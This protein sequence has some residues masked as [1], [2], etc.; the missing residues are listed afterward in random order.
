MARIARAC[1]EPR[2]TTAYGGRMPG[3]RT[4]FTVILLP[5]VV[6]GCAKRET[7]PFDG[8]R[9][10][11]HVKFLHEYGPRPAGSRALTQAADYIQ[12]K[13]KDLG[14]APQTQR[15]RE[16]E[17]KLELQN[18]WVQI[19]GEDPKD[20]PILVIGAHYDTKLCQGHP[21][22]AHNFRFVGAIDGTGGP[23]VLLELAGHVKQL[24][25]KPN[26]WLVWFDGEENLEFEWTDDN[27]ALFGSRHFVK[28][29]AAD[30]TRFPKD[31]QQRIKAMVLLDLV[32]DKNPK[33]DKDTYSNS[34]LLALFADAGD[35]MGEGARMFRTTSAIKD[36][37]LAF[38]NYGIPSI[39]LIDF[40]YRIPQ[41]RARPGETAPSDPRYFA[42]WHTD[43]DTPD[44][45]SPFGLKFFGDIVLLAL[46]AI[47]KQFFGAK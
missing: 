37:H 9:A 6:A 11:Q 8:E 43:K 34:D 27:K 35:K 23:S 38:V 10:M 45:M 5:L 25:N 36:D 44:K 16:E 4:L 12:T 46:P 39:N 29:M 30:R 18:V 19:D 33:I 32:G 17:F 15:W 13:L 3:L 26:I 1:L 7:T 24:K 2:P 14:L 40:H 20:G 42:W 47:E 22:P 28:T 31:L 21:T 41:E